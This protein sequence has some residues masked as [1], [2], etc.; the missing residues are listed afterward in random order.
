MS[1][2]EYGLDRNELMFV[3]VWGGTVAVWS[4]VRSRV[5]VI[6]EVDVTEVCVAVVVAVDILVVAAVPGAWCAW[7]DEGLAMGTDH[8]AGLVTVVKTI[9]LTGI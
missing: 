2:H 4:G 6:V 5:A 9:I 8:V 3:S 1:V 7:A